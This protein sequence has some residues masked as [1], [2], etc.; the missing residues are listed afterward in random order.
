MRVAV[1]RPTERL[2]WLDISPKAA[3]V[4]NSL[5]FLNAG[6]GSIHSALAPAALLR[7]LQE[8]SMNFLSLPYNS[9]HL[10]Y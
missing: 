6:R 9:P 8:A 4:A 1:S 5:G 7:S 10:A 3:H 2:I